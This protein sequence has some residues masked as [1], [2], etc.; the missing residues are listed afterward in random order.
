M[1][2]VILSLSLDLNRQAELENNSMI[3]AFDELNASSQLDGFDSMS[4]S[5][6][7]FTSLLN[8][9]KPQFYRLRVNTNQFK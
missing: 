8:K 4:G 1:C 7:N 3:T 2:Q 5:I 9:N 6:H